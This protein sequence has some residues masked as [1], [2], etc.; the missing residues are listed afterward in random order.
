MPLRVDQES[1]LAHVQGHHDAGRLAVLLVNPTGTGKTYTAAH[2]MQGA[3]GRGMFIV[4]RRVLLEQTS[5]RLAD[6]GIP[7]GV[8][9]GGRHDNL[10]ERVIVAS[11]QTLV[12]NKGILSTLQWAVVDEAHRGEH[13][14][15]VAELRR[16]GVRI[17]GLTATPQRGTKGLASEYDAMVVGLGYPEAVAGGLIVP[18][19][20]YAPMRPDMK[21]VRVRQGDYVE[22]DAQL[23]MH[24]LMRD[25]LGAWQKFCRGKRTIGFCVNVAHAH[26]VAKMI[27]DDGGA[28]YVIHADTPEDERK[29]ILHAWRKGPPST[30]LNVAVFAEGYDAPECEVVLNLAPTR[31]PARYL[32][33]C[34]RGCRTAPGKDH[35]MLVD[36]AGSVFEHGSPASHREWSLE[37]GE[38]KQ[39][40][41]RSAFRVCKKCFAAFEGQ[42]CPLC[43]NV[44]VA[45]KEI[46]TVDAQLQE[47]SAQIQPAAEADGK[48]RKED[49]TLE[50]TDMTR[51][52]RRLY[53]TLAPRFREPVLTQRVKDQFAERVA[54]RFQ[55]GHIMVPRHLALLW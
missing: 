45:A 52:R 3:P 20:I 53:A 48:K 54:L 1:G 16:L 12:R 37:E 32:Q 50:M 10:H 29:E 44:P 4:H 43:E 23:V 34:G 35:Y 28:A 55:E 51:L 31:S 30:L 9:Y 49:A 26:D 14:K 42:Q 13:A 2:Y 5:E 25:V 11:S 6:H 21:G 17:M 36:C 8:M 24:R 46:R 22:A 47:V 7:H 27:I 41:A 19:R 33:T 38:V 40:S 15:V 18:P 39:R